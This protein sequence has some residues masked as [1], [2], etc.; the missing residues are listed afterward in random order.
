VYAELAMGGASSPELWCGLGASLLGCRGQLV[1]K[2]FEVWAAK[3]FR[4]GAP[5]F[6]GTSYQAVVQDLRAEIPTESLGA[7]LEDGELPAMIEFLL[8][9]ERVLPEA[10]AELAESDV[11]GAVMRLGDRKSPLYVPL[12]RDAVE[13]HFGE[14]AAR[15]ALKRIGPFLDW[16][17]MRASLLT[18]REDANPDDLC[19]YLASV[20]ARLPAGW[21]EPHR[22]A[23]P[24][25][26]GFAGVDIELRSPGDDREACVALLG[27][28]LFASPRD[29]RG[30]LDFA[31]CLVKKGSPR[32]AARELCQALKEQGASV[33]L[34]GDQESLDRMTGNSAPSP[35]KKPWWKIW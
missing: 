33:E 13:G 9:T 28:H 2:P 32:L 20:L 22:A 10:I 7:S 27:E 15:S 29:A 4:R 34:H 26:R 17:E 14:G 1:R 6:S 18:A 19:P 25:Y 23:C 31:P 35:V 24:P 5:L 12:L 8:C 30:W 21:D 11:M 16:P 3:V